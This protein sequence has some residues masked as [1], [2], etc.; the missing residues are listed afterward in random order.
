[1][2]HGTADDV[3]PIQ[4]G[5]DAFAAAVCRKRWLPVEGAGHSFDEATYP[6]IVEAIHEWLSAHFG[7][8]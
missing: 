1:M 7:T 6:Q 5:L 8:E 4:D 3:V 2:I